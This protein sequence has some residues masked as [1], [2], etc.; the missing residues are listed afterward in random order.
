MAGIKKSR[1]A[2]SPSPGLAKCPTGITGLDEITGGGLPQGRPTLVCGGAGCGKTF[3]G[4]E[5]L[6]RGASQYDEPGVFVSFEES[7]KDLLENFTSN[8]FDL[9]AMLAKNKIAIDHVFIDRK[10]IEETGEYDL[11]GLFIRLDMAIKEVKAKRVVLD[12]IESLFSSFSNEGILRAELRRLFRWL[13]DKGLTAIITAE[14]GKETFTRHGLEEY[15]ADCV[16]VLDHRVEKQLSTRRLRI[17]KYRGSAHGVDEYPFLIYRTGFSML[18][19]T[20]LGLKQAVSPERISSGIDRLD[21]MLSG[22]G[23]YRGST[24]LVSGTAGTGKTS[25]AACF[26]DSVCSRGERAVYLSFEESPSQIIRNM[27]SIGIDLDKW[28]RKGLIQFHAVRPTF[29][30]LESHLKGMHRVIEDFKPAAVVV[31]PIS[32][33]VSAGDEQ[34]VKSMLMRLMDFLKGELITT[35]CTDLTAGATTVQETEIGLSSL[36]DTWI[37]LRLIENGGE[38]NRTLYIVKS[39]GMEHSEQIREFRLTD[40]GVQLLDVYVGPGGVLTGSARAAQEAQDEAE[41]LIRKQKLELMRREVERKEALYQ[42][43]LT[44]LKARFEYDKEESQLAISQSENR[45]AVLKQE[46]FYLAGIRKADLKST[47][48]GKKRGTRNEKSR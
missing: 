16:I 39:R 1:K 31:D 24:I 47:D 28:V 46:K 41:A 3:L 20:S 35:V 7:E 4:M 11:E 45:E 37:L 26:L 5:F 43:E 8:G 18:P 33:L 29:Y 2:S 15:V 48:G 10:E 12:T 44:A 40:K 21:A 38:R 23:Y 36:S 6:V 17:V 32:N 19:I 42:A 14:R 22:R 9:N 30:G 27:K 13:K 34:E 25:F